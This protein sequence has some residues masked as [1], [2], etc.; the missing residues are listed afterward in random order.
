MYKYFSDILHYNIFSFVCLP[1]FENF[2]ENVSGK[3]QWKQDSNIN[4]PVIKLN[5][6]DVALGIIEKYKD[7]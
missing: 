4:A 2:M 6:T 7:R 5:G 1:V 3:K